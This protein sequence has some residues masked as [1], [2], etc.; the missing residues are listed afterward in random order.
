MNSALLKRLSA[1]SQH[2][3]L[4]LLGV[5]ILIKAYTTLSWR[6]E[7]DTPL[8]QYIAFLIDKFHYVPYRDIFETS[9]PGTFLFHYLI[10]HFLGYG[11]L[12]FQWVNLVVLTLLMLVTYRFMRRFGQIIGLWSV[13]LF[14]L[15]Y[16]A[17]GQTM[18]LQKD[19][20]G[21]IPISVAFLCIP[22]DFKT[23]TTPLRFA[24]VG[25]M[26]GIALIIKPH[27]IITLPI[28]FA[29]LLAFRQQSE[30]LSWQNFLSAASITFAGLLVPLSIVLLWLYQH[31]ALITF[32]DMFSQ[33]LPLHTAM[34]GD[35]VTIS[36]LSRIS[37]LL[38]S[39]VRFSVYG[40][41]LL[42]ALL[43]YFQFLMHK[44]LT[45]NK[46]L[47]L[48][49]GCLALSTLAYGIYPTLA[50]KFWRYHYLPFA[51]F[52]SISTALC[53]LPMAQLQDTKFI[54][55]CK[56]LLISLFMLV[57]VSLHGQLPAFLAVLGS[58]LFHGK[59]SHIP[60]NGRVDDIISWLK[61]RLNPGDLVQP[62]DW[63]GGAI[64]AMLFSEAQLATRYIYD[65]Y[66][67]HHLS[68]PFI[69]GLRQAFICQMTQLR[70]RFIIDVPGE[71]KPWVS[72]VDTT[73]EF[74]ELRDFI[75]KNYK[76]AHQGNN[77]IIYEII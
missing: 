28:V 57:A 26:Y 74:P 62:L 38:T 55:Y 71:D 18:Y 58:D 4:A 70:P 49:L 44:Q 6:Y 68:N 76:P 50:G 63:T 39:T 12:A 16:L 2:P 69:Q 60:K 19:Y 51:Y 17:E 56:K 7:M 9:M 40:P 67:Y 65:Y 13:A 29:T 46:A 72:G 24:L 15:I 11:D 42:S 66:F 36:G 21:L 23:A 10:V 20:I 1:I 75:A 35:H 52:C 48:F 77:Y 8:L 45:Q 30:T 32:L 27:L 37:Y 47:L 34:T 41:L 5:L 33:Y 73:R 14:C 43:G 54:Y 31:E 64:H 25:L 22:F 3:V 53:L 61:P 59:E